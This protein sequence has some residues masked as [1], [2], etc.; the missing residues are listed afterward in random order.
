MNKLTKLLSVFV[1]AGAMA[2]A[3]ALA[4]CGHKHVYEYVPDGASGHHQ[5]CKDGDDTKDIV[6]HNYGDDNVCDDCG[7]VNEVSETVAVTG[8]TLDKTTASLAVGGTETLTPTVAPSDATN[9]NVTWTSSDPAVATVAN[10]V[11][12][13]VAAGTATITV[14]TADGSK[15]AE[16][17]VT[18]TDAT[19]TYKDV[20]FELNVSDKFES[21][22]TDTDRKV[23]IFAVGANT[24]VRNRTKNGVFENKEGGA[25]VSEAAYTKSIKLGGTGDAFI[26]NAPAAGTLV[27]HIQN[28]SSGTTTVQTVV[29]NK[30]D[31]T[32]Q[33]IEYQATDGSP[34][35]EVEIEL[36]EAGEYKITRTGGTSDIYYAKF[37]CTV[38]DT[39]L[40][41]IEVVAAGTVDYYVGQTYSS[42]GL[43]LNKVFSITQRTEPLEVTDVTVDDSKVDMTK[44]GVYPV[45][46]KYTEEGK[47]YKTSFNVTVYAVESLRIG[48]NAIKDGIKNSY[49][50]IYVNQALRQLY[51]NGD[52]FS[53]DGM[54]V[55]LSGKVT[56]D[57]ADKTR[58]FR[59]AAGAFTLTG[60]STA[61]S[62]KTEVTVTL[63]G[64][65]TNVKFTVY[66][67][68]KIEALK[69]ADS[70]N[71]NVDGALAEDK[72]GTLSDDA[73]AAYQ[74]KTIQ[75]AVD[76]LE[77]CGIKDDA[78]KTMTIA[79]GTYKEKVEINIP[80]L[81]VIGAGIGETGYT[82]IE[83]DSLF[84]ETDE[85]GFVHTTDSTS[86]FNV[87]E[88][89]VGFTMKNV[90]VSNAYNSLAYFD[91]VKGE[92]FPEH[93]ALAMLI[94]ADQV[95]IDSCKFLGYQDT[96]E[97]F[98][99]RQIV[100]NSYISG[101]TDFIFGTNNTT[102]F[103]K[104]TITSIAVADSA[105]HGG[106]IT[107]F[108]GNNGTGTKITYGAIFDD[109]D[110][111]CEEG[112]TIAGQPLKDK[113]GNPV[114]EED[115]VTPKLTVGLTAL[116]RPW[117]Q[118]AAVMY[119]NC[120][121]GSHIS[122]VAATGAS[123]D[124]RYVSMSGNVA[125][126][127]QYTEY[128][129]TG[130]GAITASQ[131]GV[132]VLTDAAAAALYNDFY[133]IFAMTN[134]QITYKNPWA[135]TNE[136]VSLTVK[137]GTDDIYAGEVYKNIKLTAAIAEDWFTVEGKVLSGLFT[138]EACE[139]AFDYATALSATTVLY[140]TFEDADPTV[141]AYVK[142]V[143][144]Q[145][146]DAPVKYGKIQFSGMAKNND[147]LRFDA[148]SEITFKAVKG[149]VVTMTTY[150][151]AAFTINGTEVVP[152][153]KVATY[154]VTAD[155]DVSIKRASGTAYIKTLEIYVPVT[156]TTTIDLTACDTQFQ[157]NAGVWNGLMIDATTG[158]F[159][160][161]GSK[162]WIQFNT[163]TVIK[164]YVAE[165][166]TV[167]F[168]EYNNA[169]SITATVEGNLATITA[170]GN[171]YIKN[172]TVTCTVQANVLAAFTAKSDDIADATFTADAPTN[173]DAKGIIKLYS[174]SDKQWSSDG[175]AKKYTD[176]DGNQITSVKRLKPNGA[177]PYIQIDLTGY[178]GEYTLTMAYA[179]SGSSERTI[180]VTAEG[181]STPVFTK[182]TTASDFV[183]AETVTLE[184]GKVYKITWT[185]GYNFY[186]L[187]I[188][189]KA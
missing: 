136:K 141:K 47:D 88:K 146:A 126:K 113:D 179:A 81:T 83:W 116:G 109:C 165:G 155:G 149:S 105:S 57:G 175:N 68:D 24:E 120:R 53:T 183:A 148:E 185:N 130:D 184:G 39:P 158:K 54:T 59:L 22:K 14:T 110:F 42:A 131:T 74:F 98:T 159:A 34:V 43:E 114:Y 170:T 150:D 134:G 164:L 11:V 188:A 106:Y 40:E 33:N 140:A 151:A 23:S 152:V 156:E 63:N 119:M 30:P 80:N 17:A 125:D 21:T 5:E 3:G 178:T 132:T 52:T 90:I 1:I 103:N 139:T 44:A 101:T 144:D 108:K 77:N 38:Q 70:V 161:N 121:L 19:P 115:G 124:E 76:F 160:L 96:I 84:G 2:G 122:K 102:Y 60:N 8:V 71:V 176:V 7:Y 69:T 85:S 154:T 112:V 4:G 169:G 95:V 93:R 189:P 31:G 16:C 65:E 187:S 138:D 104:C 142:Y 94:Q 123:R 37:S 61:T 51:F 64:T 29:L 32:T 20:T 97:F 186:G 55:I 91:Q 117:G 67:I 163:G 6:D 26:I 87:R 167:T 174:A 180:N 35:R 12:T 41:S 58:E 99:G 107:A 36:A 143:Y 177:S 78:A 15:T 118:D 133:T 145:N 18:V 27:I 25:Q 129:N 73:T 100:T 82:M 86:T 137:V 56:V 9:K 168:T 10:G 13:A 153:E 75:Q 45:E 89:A 46:V 50:G 182:T 157:G 79:A 28:G 166:S 135:G 172:I 48:T 66:V 127:A 111:V 62:G 173:W 162:D 49:N 128:N 72:I 171:T 92:K 181:A 147:W